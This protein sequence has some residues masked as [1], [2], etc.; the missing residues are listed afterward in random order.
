MKQLLAIFLGGGIGASAR[1][2]LSLQIH[3]ATGP[4]FPFGILTVNVLGSFLIGILWVLLIERFNLGPIWRASLLIGLL[5]GFT[6]FSSFSIDTINLMLRGQIMSATLYI[7]LSV[8]LCLIGTW[9][10]ILIGRA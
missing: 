10:G 8:I 1:Y 6:T 7:L 4:G 5:G 9:F 3:K 2:L